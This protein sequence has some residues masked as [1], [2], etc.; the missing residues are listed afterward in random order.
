M[1]IQ[2]SRYE[3]ITDDLK[4]RF[5]DLVA[6]GYTRP[7]AAAALGANPRQLRACCSPQSHRYDDKFAKAYAKLTEKGG[8]H[9]TGLVERLRTAGIER[10]IRS[11]DRLLEKYSIIHDPDWSVH[12]PQSMQINFNIAEVR[13]Q[14]SAELEQLP[15]R[16]LRAYVEKKQRELEEADIIDAETS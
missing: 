15:D 1:A 8:E 3:E 9:E 4:E 12:R 6:Q 7:E 16:D 5:L 10:A 13:A 11:S 2:G 14:I